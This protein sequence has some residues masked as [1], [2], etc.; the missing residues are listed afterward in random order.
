VYALTAPGRA[1]QGALYDQWE[2]LN[3][4][5]ETLDRASVY[6]FALPPARR[7]RGAP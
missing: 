1:L 3:A 6:Q 7:G 5:I 4:V 2:Q